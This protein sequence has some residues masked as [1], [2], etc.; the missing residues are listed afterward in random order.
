MHGTDCVRMKWAW[1]AF[2]SKMRHRVTPSRTILPFATQPH[3]CR[4]SSSSIKDAA[5]RARA[6][7]KGTTTLCGARTRPESAAARDCR[8]PGSYFR[9]GLVS[10]PETHLG[11]ESGDRC[12]GS[13]RMSAV[14]CGL[15]EAV[16]PGAMAATDITS[17]RDAPL[18]RY[19]MLR[20]RRLLILIREYWPRRWR[21]C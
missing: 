2:S 1:R 19:D 20:E 10:K 17:A 18:P 9:F 4:A 16:S 15:V 5:S 7:D 11:G 12:P 8:Q 13:C 14:R 21:H 6:T 3:P